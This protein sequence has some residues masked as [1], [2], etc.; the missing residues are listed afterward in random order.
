MSAREA[1]KIKTL[2]DTLG[3]I[4]QST[5]PGTMLQVK[6]DV[7]DAALAV[8]ARIAGSGT[9]SFLSQKSPVGSGHGSI[10]A[11]AGSRFGEYQLNV[12]DYSRSPRNHF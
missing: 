10:V 11:S 4:Q 6:P 9:L 5:D 3:A 8:V 1:G 2:F 12:H 7:T